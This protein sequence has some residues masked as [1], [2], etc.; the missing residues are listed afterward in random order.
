MPLFDIATSLQYILYHISRKNSIFIRKFSV[1]RIITPIIRLGQQQNIVK[2]AKRQSVLLCLLYCP[3]ASAYQFNFIRNCYL[4]LFILFKL[5][6]DI[7]ERSRHCYIRIGQAEQIGT[8]LNLS[9]PC[10]NHFKS[11]HL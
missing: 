11:H 7:A 1:Y 8:Q 2:T 9:K 3:S 4:R 5:D 6:I 10:L